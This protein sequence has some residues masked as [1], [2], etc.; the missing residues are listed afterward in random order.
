LQFE[1]IKKTPVK[2]TIM[3]RNLLFPL[4][5]LSVVI[6]LSSC[7]SKNENISQ[8]RGINRDG[9]YND[10]NLLKSWPEGGPELLWSSDTIGNGYGAAVVSQGKVFVNGEIDSTSHLFAFDLHGKLLWKAPFGK[11][12]TGSGFSSNFPG[13]RSTPTV[14]NDLVYVSSGTGRIACFEAETGKERWMV[15]MV[16][17]LKG[18]ANE[19]GYSESLLI[20][21][22]VVFCY[23]GGPESNVVA[24]NR[25]HGTPVWTSKALGDTVSFCSPLMVE[26]SARKV[27]VT[28][29]IRA[30]FGLDAVTGE[31]L[32][33]H[34]QD[35]IKYGVQGNTP[36]YRDGCLYYVGDS[37]GAVKLKLADDGKSVQE[38]WRN[39][40]MSNGTGG[41]VIVKDKLYGTSDNRKM[42][43]FDTGTGAIIDSVRVSRGGTIYADGNLYCY[44]D[45]NEVNLISLE[46]DKM[47]LVNSF[48]CNLGTKEAMAHPAIGEGM[49]LI[50]HGKTLMAFKIGV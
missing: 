42:L 10:Q 20:D 9:I 48:K 35:S 31:L 39:P 6:N 3:T 1:F 11:E 40:E 45:R 47:K 22:N 23:P 29:S 12:F 49:L 25:F 46:G 5:I 18:L 44:T 7:K 21:G 38:V 27:L 33:S 43:A 14:V 50:R 19:F 15:D 37:N 24:L 41:F 34:K 26:L 32:W 2:L 16:K 30:V 8:W 36:V 4:F 13:N 28:F 17:D